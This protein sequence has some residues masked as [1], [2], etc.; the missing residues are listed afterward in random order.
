VVFEEAGVVVEVDGWA[1][2]IDPERFQRDRA[3]QNR[4]V[5]AGWTVLR[6]TWRDLT[7][8]SEYV[9]ATITSILAGRTGDEGRDAE[10]RR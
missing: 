1:Y 8:R 4:L 5:A 10:Y 9:V 6:F 3:R 7:E 2:H